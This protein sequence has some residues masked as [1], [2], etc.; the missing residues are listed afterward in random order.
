VGQ[1]FLPAAGFKPAPFFSKSE[2]NLNMPHWYTQPVLR[3]PGNPKLHSL[4]TEPDPVEWARN[5]FHWQ[6]DPIQ[7][8]IL[9]TSSNRLMLC[10]TRQWGKSTVT[11]IKALHHA[12]YH[13]GALVIV[14]APTAR[15][16]GEWVE[17]TS[18]FLRQLDIHPRGDGRNQNSLLL[19]NRSRIVGLA[20]I[21]NHIRGFSR[22][23]LLIIDEAAFV[24]DPLYHALNPMLAV[25]SGALWL[26]STPNG[27]AGF[28]YHEWHS[29]NTPTPQ[30]GATPQKGA[31]IWQRTQVTADRCPRILPE[32][33]A[34]QRLALGDQ[35][36]RQEY[37]CEFL[38]TG[39]Q[40]FS[41]ELL[42]QA[43]DDLY[44]PI[45][46]GRPLWKE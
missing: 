25:S 38:S 19:P 26:M 6:P 7:A 36:Y 46:G 21:P 43:F 11:A 3:K 45:N 16:S 4:P 37:Q 35:M 2:T 5:K 44:D 20:G 39:S 12:W 24:P 9:R 28:F 40:V 32:F 1:A 13:P 30:D 18:G 23:A 42:Q 10:C 22:V 41:Q 29:N 14:A 8:E 34:Q 31:T 27:Q 33:L 17:K 15:Q